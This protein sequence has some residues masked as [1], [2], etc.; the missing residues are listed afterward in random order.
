MEE[1]QHPP[2]FRSTG[3]L[4]ADFRHSLEDYDVNAAPLLPEDHSARIVDVGCGWGQFLW[5]LGSR[6]YTRAEGIDTGAE[7]VRYCQSLGL[8]A[9][10]VAD[11]A[12]FLRDRPAQ[13][14]LITMN[15]IIEHVDGPAGLELLRAAHGS[16][17][18]GGRVMVQT[19]NMNATS[20]SYARYVEMT[21]VTGYT[22]NSLGE[23]LYMAGF[24][25]V[26]VVGNKTKLRLA[27]RRVLWLMLQFAS[28]LLWR[29]MLL[30]EL[31]S[32]AP[33]ILSKN[34]Y[35]VADRA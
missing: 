34:L 10:H 13:Y 32:D 25:N 9:E 30:A 18:P 17:R 2:T 7:Q 14:D 11:S 15:H 33:R 26:R 27:P 31:G 12:A 5:W 21:H 16:L 8:R 28:R 3:D 35:A 20:A 29:A 19:P 22:D 4:A 24:V 23:A 6:G 1:Y